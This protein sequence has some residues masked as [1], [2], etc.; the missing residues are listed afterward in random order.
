MSTTKVTYVGEGPLHGKT[1]LAMESYRGERDEGFLFLQFDDLTLEADGVSLAHGWHKYRAD[2][3]SMDRP[4]F[5]Q[6]FPAFPPDPLSLHL[7]FCHC[8]C[9]Q[10]LAQVR[11]ADPHA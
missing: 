8:G 10:T 2:L 4:S 6:E 9:G 7:E 1:A 5:E 3:L 11:E